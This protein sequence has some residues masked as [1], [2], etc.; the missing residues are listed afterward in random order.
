MSFEK[1]FKDLR[2]SVINMEGQVVLSRLLKDIPKGFITELDLGDVPSGVYFVRFTNKK[3]SGTAR[4][5]VR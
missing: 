3:I 2:L 5:I 1:P 4:I